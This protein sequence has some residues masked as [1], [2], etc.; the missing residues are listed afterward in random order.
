MNKGSYNTIDQ[1]KNIEKGSNVVRFIVGCN[2][3]LTTTT[4]FID[5]MSM[6]FSLVNFP[7]ASSAKVFDS[8]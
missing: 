3:G 8:K 1:V 7:A 6:P 5:T 4:T 2:I